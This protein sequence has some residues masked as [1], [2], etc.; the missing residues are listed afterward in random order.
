MKSG[1]SRYVRPIVTTGNNEARALSPVIMTGRHDRETPYAPLR[2][3]TVRFMSIF[4]RFILICLWDVCSGIC[5][6]GRKDVMRSC[7]VHDRHKSDGVEGG[8][9]VGQ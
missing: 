5:D 7:Q 8:R 2:C 3:L 4:F 1:I 6:A 9:D